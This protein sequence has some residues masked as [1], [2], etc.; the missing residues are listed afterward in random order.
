MM[1]TVG[2]FEVG[3]RRAVRRLEYIDVVISD[4]SAAASGSD[5][6]ASKEG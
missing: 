3:E 4:S 6:E 2:G 1:C 5:N